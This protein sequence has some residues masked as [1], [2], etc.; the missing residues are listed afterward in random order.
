M[1]TRWSNRP[2]VA[3]AAGNLAWTARAVRA[4]ARWPAVSL[5]ALQLLLSLAPAASLRV[6]QHV[7]NAGLA[8]AARGP[9]ALTSLLPWLA[10]LA[11]TMMLSSGVAFQLEEPLSTRLGQQ[12]RGALSR[13]RLEKAARLPWPSEAPKDAVVGTSFARTGL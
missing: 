5:I 4:H 13:L 7:I 1:Y 8:A 9:S 6:T 11:A 10:A 12:L 3:Q 2:P